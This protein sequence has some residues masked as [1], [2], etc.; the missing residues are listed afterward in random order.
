MKKAAK[1]KAGAKKTAS[2]KK[3]P[4]ANLRDVRQKVRN[5]VGELAPKIA[6]AVAEDVGNKAQVQSMKMLFEVIGLFPESPEEK[7]VVEDD[8]ALAKVLLERLGFSDEP[9]VS[10]EEAAERKELEESARAAMA[11]P[12][13]PVE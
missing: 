9:V 7:Q 5:V 13:H 10:E 6:K 4:V 12:V 3:A 8:Q 11:T 2:A 1:K